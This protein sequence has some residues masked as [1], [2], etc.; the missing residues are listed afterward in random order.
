MNQIHPS[1]VIDSTARIGANV[2]IGPNTVIEA[3]VIIGDNCILD[4]NVI[5]AK[6]VKIGSG[7]IFF[8]MCCIGKNPQMLGAKPDTL[9][10]RLE[11]G[12]N[13]VIRE[14]VTIHPSI[15]PD[16]TTRIG[17]DN[18]IMCGVHVGHDCIIENKCVISNNTQISGHCKIEEG[19]WLS[20]LIAIHQFVTVGRWCY[21][22]GFTGTSHDLPPFVMVSGHYPAEVR[23]I[24]KRGLNRAGLNPQQQAAILAAFKKL[25]RTE[26]VIVEKARAMLEDTNLDENV[27]LM[28]QSIV[29]SSLHRNGRYLET[30]RRH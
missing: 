13:N 27:R 4:A 6:N 7:N 2:K 22:A 23:A 9:F 10:G 30:F 8:P 5:I 18:M 17:D 3:G 20:G 1:A 16:G 24:N 12:N 19:V 11:I 15:Y 21:A 26:G 25:Y 29:N 14:L 28:A